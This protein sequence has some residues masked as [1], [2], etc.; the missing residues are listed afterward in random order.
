MIETPCLLD[1]D[2]FSYLLRGEEPVY[3]IAMEYLQRYKNFT[4]SCITFYENL[5]GHIASGAKKR[6]DDFYS[7][8][9]FTEIIYFDRAIIETASEIYGTLKRIG[10]LPGDADIFIA[11]TAL[12]SRK[13]LVTNNERHYE[14][15]KEHF[16]LNVE[17]W[18]ANQAAFL[19]FDVDEQR[20]DGESGNND[21]KPELNA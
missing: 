6:L 18:K 15:I 17:N 1:S 12:V 13:T 16:A 3:S 11:A 9:V 19:Q 20:E 8:L 10:A 21:I 7:L 2:I 4:I 14:A 5:R